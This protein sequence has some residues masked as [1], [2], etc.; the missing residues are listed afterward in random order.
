MPK[1][2]V[3]KLPARSI[4]LKSGRKTRRVIYRHTDNYFCTYWCLYYGKFVELKP[5]NDG[6]AMV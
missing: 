3:D 1:R 5:T 2:Y 4:L 6:F